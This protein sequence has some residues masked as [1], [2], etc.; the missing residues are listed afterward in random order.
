MKT[1]TY[2]GREVYPIGETPKVTLIRMRPSTYYRI[3]AKAD[4]TQTSL[5]G[6][7]NAALEAYLDADVKKAANTR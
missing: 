7:L 1:K 2:K 4:E 6:T 5:N 3:R